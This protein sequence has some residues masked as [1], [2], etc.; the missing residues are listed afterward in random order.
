MA[1]YKDNSVGDLDKLLS[2]AK[3][4]RTRFESI[5]YLN[6]CYYVGEQ[7]VYLLEPWQDRPA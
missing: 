5:W 3:G 7:W 2:M 1:Y 6:Q 4:P